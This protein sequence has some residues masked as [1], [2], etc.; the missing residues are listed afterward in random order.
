[1]AKAARDLFEKP[2][3]QSVEMYLPATAVK[4]LR[5]NAKLA[6]VSVSVLV[7]DLLREAG[8]KI[9]AADYVDKRTLPRWHG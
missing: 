1:M 5:E 6:G 7:M 8:Y 9:E 4:E 2:P 3:R